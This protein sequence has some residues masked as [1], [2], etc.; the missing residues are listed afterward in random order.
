MPKKQKKIVEKAKPV[1]KAPGSYMRENGILML[2][3]KFDQENIMPLVTQIME[4][5]MMDE[6]LQPDSITIIIVIESGCS[7]SSI[8]LYSII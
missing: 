6:E 3:D 4:Y 5:N 8:M 1:M 2:V 7:S